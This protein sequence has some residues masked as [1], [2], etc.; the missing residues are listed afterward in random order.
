M[1]ASFLVTKPNC[2][3]QD[4]APLIRPRWWVGGLTGGGDVIELGK[5][6]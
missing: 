2:A 5:A 6:R 4:A 1:L 3:E